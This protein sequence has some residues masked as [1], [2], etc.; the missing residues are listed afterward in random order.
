GSSRSPEDASKI[1]A[2]AASAAETV[3]KILVRGFFLHAGGIDKT[4][5]EVDVALPKNNHKVLRLRFPRWRKRAGALLRSGRPVH[6][7][8]TAIVEQHERGAS[9]L[10]W[11]GLAARLQCKRDYQQPDSKCN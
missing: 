11:Q 7:W 10:V 9:Q 6:F 1:A 5:P 4:L 2:Q 3:R 8:G